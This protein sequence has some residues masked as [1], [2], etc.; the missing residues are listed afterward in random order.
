MMLGLLTVFSLL[1]STGRVG[2]QL[3]SLRAVQPRD[4]AASLIIMVSILSLTVFL[5]SPIIFAAFMDQV[6]HS[7]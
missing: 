5:P 3:V 2:N 6:S 1:G 4:K 7:D